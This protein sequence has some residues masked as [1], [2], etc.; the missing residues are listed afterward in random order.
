VQSVP[1]YKKNAQSASRRANA[2][3]YLGCQKLQHLDTSVQ[4]QFLHQIRIA[5]FCLMKN[6]PNAWKLNLIFLLS[7]Y[8]GKLLVK[9]FLTFTVCVWF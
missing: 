5:R 4:R 9:T 1:S 7:I 2:F 8:T 6:F 3:C